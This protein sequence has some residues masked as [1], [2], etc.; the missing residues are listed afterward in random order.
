MLNYIDTDLWLVLG[1]F[2]FV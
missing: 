2:S 1:F